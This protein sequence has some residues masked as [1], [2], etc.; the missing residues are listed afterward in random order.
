MMKDENNDS[1]KGVVLNFPSTR[2]NGSKNKKSPKASS[3]GI[4]RL[5]PDVYL[6]VI[7]ELVDGEHYVTFETHPPEFDDVEL[8]EYAWTLLCSLAQSNEVVRKEYF[9]DDADHLFFEE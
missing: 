4:V 9:G 3:D 8:A 1:K 7:N 2:S 5:K 6:R